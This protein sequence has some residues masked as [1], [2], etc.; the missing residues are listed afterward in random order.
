M[1]AP[2]STLIGW[3]CRRARTHAN[4][5]TVNVDIHTPSLSLS[6]SFSPSPTLYDTHQ[7]LESRALY[8]LGN[9]YHAR[10]KSTSTV[11]L[12]SNI[13]QQDTEESVKSSLIQAARHYE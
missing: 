13:D 11:G 10:G 4:I 9:V 1:Q 3:S 5:Y 7:V 8:N 2:I 6:L 12:A